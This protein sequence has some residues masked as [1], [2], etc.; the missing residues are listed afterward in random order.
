MNIKVVELSFPVISG[1]EWKSQQLSKPISWSKYFLCSIEKLS[2]FGHQSN[3]I[4]PNFGDP[5]LYSKNQ[6]FY[7]QNFKKQDFFC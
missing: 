4:T 1:V 5:K 6:V 2:W 3:Q 7:D